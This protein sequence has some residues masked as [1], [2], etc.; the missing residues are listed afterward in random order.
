MGIHRRTIDLLDSFSEK[1][2]AFPMCLLVNP[3][4]MPSLQEIGIDL[5]ILKR[6]NLTMFKTGIY[7]YNEELYISAFID[8]MLDASEF[9]DPR[10]LGLI[11]E[12][13]IEVGPASPLN[14]MGV[15][16]GLV[17][18]QKLK[19][20]GESSPIPWMSEVTMGRWNTLG[21]FV[22]ISELDITGITSGFGNYEWFPMFVRVLKCH[23]EFITTN[24]ALPDEEKLLRIEH[25]T[26]VCYHSYIRGNTLKFRKVSHLTLKQFS[27][28]SRFPVEWFDEFLKSCSEL[29]NL[30]IEWISILEIRAWYASFRRL[31]RL[32]ILNPILEET[33]RRVMRAVHETESSTLPLNRLIEGYDNFK[34]LECKISRHELIS[35]E[36]LKNV[37]KKSR[38]FQKIEIRCAWPRVNSQYYNT[39]LHL[40]STERRRR[41]HPRRNSHLPVDPPQGTY[42]LPDEMSPRKLMESM[43]SGIDDRRE[44]FENIP[45]HMFCKFSPD[46]KSILRDEKERLSRMGYK[47]DLYGRIVT[48]RVYECIL[49][50]NM[51]EFRKL[52]TRYKTNRISRLF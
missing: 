37:A 1:Q 42:Y 6:E 19:L 33:G 50:I 20:V 15:L 27:S 11:D 52:L 2:K 48:T 30:E 51:A 24:R 34:T 45:I 44:W 22:T 9:N 43:F 5:R 8:V 3:A 26:I 39:H 32:H 36:I 18:L 29:V 46:T 21:S 7:L 47:L 38:L 35:Y 14:A 23:Q 16:D 12:M 40:A 41:S 17:N 31:Q 28:K 4:Y 10:F 25:L 13:T 49:I